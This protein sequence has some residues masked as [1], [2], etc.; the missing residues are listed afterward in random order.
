MRPARGAAGF[1]AEVQIRHRAKPT[2]ALVTQIGS[3]RWQVE[4][5]EAVWAAAP[6]QAAVFYRG[7]E[8][9]GGGRIVRSD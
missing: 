5:E 7:A 4:T 8:V 9:L 1:G 3:G 2:P 6:G